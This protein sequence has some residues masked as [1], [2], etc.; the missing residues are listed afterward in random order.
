MH[1]KKIMRKI[2]SSA[3]STI[4]ASVRFKFSSAKVQLRTGGIGKAQLSENY[5]ILLR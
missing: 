5:L 1:F 4:L 2:H 3:S